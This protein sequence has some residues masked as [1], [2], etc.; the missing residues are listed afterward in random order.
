MRGRCI[1]LHLK[2]RCAEEMRFN[3]DERVLRD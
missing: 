3:G 2:V 1:F